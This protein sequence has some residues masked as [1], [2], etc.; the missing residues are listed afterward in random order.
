MIFRM[1]RRRIRPTPTG[2]T[3]P[4]GCRHHDATATDPPHDRHVSYRGA[5]PVPA[6]RSKP[7][8]GSNP[9]TPAERTH[10]GLWNEPT[11]DRSPKDTTGP[12]ASRT[13]AATAVACPGRFRDKLHLNYD[14]RHYYDSTQGPGGGDLVPP[15]PWFAPTWKPGGN[16]PIVAFQTSKMAE[17]THSRATERTHSRA[18]ERTHPRRTHSAGAE[19]T[20]SRRAERTHSRAGTN[21]LSPERTHSRAR[22]EPT[23]RRRNEPTFP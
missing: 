13:T 14:L 16:E 9:F 20:H 12:A 23:S 19:R 5:R 18:T 11:F 7:P 22:N 3:D 21:P 8:G 10:P 6:S 1:G 4:G 2:P 15:I 17:R